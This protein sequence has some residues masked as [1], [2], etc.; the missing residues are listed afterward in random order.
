MGGEGTGGAPRVGDV[1]AA[2]LD[3]AAPAECGGCGRP[4]T[5]W[6]RRCASVVVD[7]PIA[8]TPRVELDVA[9]W[10]AGRYRGPLARAVVELKEHRRRDLIPVLGQV[11][12]HGLLRLAEWE[13]LPAARRLALI[14]A[15]TR[16][17]AARRR[18]GD[19]V[20][21]IARSAADRLG[22][23]VAVVPMLA[24]APWTRDSAGL[25][26]GRRM[27]NLHGAVAVSRTRPAGLRPP[28][29]DVA[30]VLIDDVLTTG[31]TAAA[32]VAALRG[33]GITVASAVVVASA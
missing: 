5:P 29:R 16:A 24:T 33:A 22:P 27:A 10:A 6:C 8:L 12:S 13:Q 4:G 32:A 19:P 9:A 20:T 11:L 3:L 23:H 30:V 21:A 15:P 1:L 28:H 31:A 17:V 25:S 26:A 14:P 2:A 7:D 18:G